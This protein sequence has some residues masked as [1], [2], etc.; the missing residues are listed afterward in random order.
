MTHCSKCEMAFPKVPGISHAS[1][2]AMSLVPFLKR[3]QP[4]IEKSLKTNFVSSE[5]MQFFFSC[6]DFLNNTVF[7]VG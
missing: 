7:I 1:Q 6:H 3:H 5:Y 4:R 2:P